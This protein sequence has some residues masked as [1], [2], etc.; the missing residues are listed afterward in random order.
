MQ[1]AKKCEG[2]QWT[3]GA[4]Q[5]V[6]T[7]LETWW[8]DLGH[9]R[10]HLN[11]LLSLTLLAFTI[12]SLLAPTLL[13]HVL[14][15]S[16][17]LFLLLLHY[18]IPLTQTWKL[19]KVG[20]IMPQKEA[21]GPR[22]CDP[23]VGHTR[24]SSFKRRDS[25][26]LPPSH[27]SLPLQR[28]PSHSSSSSTMTSSVQKFCISKPFL[29]QHRYVYHLVAS[30]WLLTTLTWLRILSPQFLQG[31]L[32]TLLENAARIAILAKL[33]EKGS[34][35]LKDFALLRERRGAAW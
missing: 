5:M 31:F 21:R 30:G 20:R 17:L 12:P 14:H 15:P 10:H 25:P 24:T 23:S 2:S 6:A 35:F 18:H 8:S 3:S 32:W 9:L 7:T 27:L 33:M 1:G 29:E 26:S 34:G 16:T 28:L 19:L 22:K 4:I 13:D 11:I